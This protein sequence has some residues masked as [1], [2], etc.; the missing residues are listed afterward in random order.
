MPL[1][2]QREANMRAE[3]L[4]KALAGIYVQSEKEFDSWGLSSAE[5]EIALLMLKGLR[6]KEIASARG[7]SERTV[8]QQAQAVYKKAGLDGRADLAAYFIEDFLQS[9]EPRQQ[10]KI[11]I[12]K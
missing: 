11:F 5:R 2:R 9:M 12:S 3:E 7:T 8:R 4:E 1:C 6:L 10:E